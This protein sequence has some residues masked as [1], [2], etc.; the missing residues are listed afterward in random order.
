[1]D[2]TTV[3]GKRVA[4]IFRSSHSMGSR[5]S[6]ERLQMRA[7]PLQKDF[8]ELG[9]PWA[10]RVLLKAAIKDIKTPATKENENIR[11]QGYQNMASR[12][13]VPDS[14]VSHACNAIRCMTRSR[15]SSGWT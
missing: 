2:S 13:V 15:L 7:C 12:Q 14:Q 1:M 5:Q 3:L 9:R 6:W 8:H 4:V 11:N 10:T